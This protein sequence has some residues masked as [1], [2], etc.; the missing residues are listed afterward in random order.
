MENILNKANISSSNI[1]DSK[2]NESI[3]KK[4]VPSKNVSNGYSKNNTNTLS[5]TKKPSASKLG[6]NKNIA[7]PP[8]L[9]FE[10]RSTFPPPA[11][12]F[13]N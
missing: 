6:K 2:I 5:F 10:S 13:E 3:I 8:P 7:P 12:Q 1:K 11:V 9:P 4:A